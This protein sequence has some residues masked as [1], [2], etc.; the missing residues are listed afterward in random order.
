MTEL[1]KTSRE[2]VD[3]ALA[4]ADQLLTLS[5]EN[6]GVW[7]FCLGIAR[8]VTGPSFAEAK[9]WTQKVE[10]PAGVHWYEGPDKVRVWAIYGGNG[11]LT[12]QLACYLLA[13]KGD[14]S[15]QDLGIP[16]DEPRKLL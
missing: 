1:V 14:L 13:G 12:S 6:P 7:C 11:G 15:G 10:L 4:A 16:A 9:R 5:K 2:F 3:R 8:Q